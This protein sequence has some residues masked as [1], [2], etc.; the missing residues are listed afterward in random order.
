MKE[1]KYL[2]DAQ[3]AVRLIY[4]G[5]SPRLS[6]LRDSDYKD[7]LKHYG[8][9]SDFRVLVDDL[10][11]MLELKVLA[12]LE[13]S[14]I[15]TPDTKDSVFAARLIDWRSGLGEMHQVAIALI[16]VAIAATFY[17]TASALADAEVDHVPLTVSARRIAETLLDL[18][19]RLEED[20]SD[21]PDPEDAGLA[22]TWRELARYPLTKPDSSNR[23]GFGSLV[24]MVKLVLNQLVESGMVQLYKTTEQDNYVSM[25]RYRVQIRELAATELF[26]RCVAVLPGFLSEKSH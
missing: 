3:K 5:L 1:P 2:S 11:Q 20:V 6:A 15:L 9:D 16:H 22:E 26:K 18:C 23:A 7:L 25:P 8:A 24:A 14:I 10:A 4:K 13:N 17:P 12:V 19:Q 21:D